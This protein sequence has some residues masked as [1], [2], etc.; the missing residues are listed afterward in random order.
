MTPFPPIATLR[1]WR[2]T[3]ATKLAMGAALALAA[4]VAIVGPARLIAQ[5]EGERGIIPMARSTDIEVS[6]VEVNVSGKTGQEAREN[7]WREAY[8]KAWAVL[9]GPNMPDAAIAA[10]VSAVVIENEQIGPHRYIAKLTV[11]FDRSK[12]G[13]YVGGGESGEAVAHSA[14][15]LL[16]PLLYSG[17]VGQV[18]E[19]RGPWQRAWAEFRAGTSP[20]DYVRPV[21][22]GGDSLLLTA[23]QV[24]RRSRTWWR[25]VLDEFGASDV[26]VPVAR[27]E[28]QWPGGPVRG[29][30]TARYGP[31]NTFLES[32]AMT[33]NDESG[34]PAM[35]AKAVQRF[36]SIY[37]QALAQGLLQPDPTLNAQA[38]TISPALAALIAESQRAEQSDAAPRPSASPGAPSPTPSATATSAP[39]ASFTIQ[40]PTPDARAVDTA[41]AVVRSAPGVQGASTSSIAIGGTSVVRASFA[42]DAAALASALRGRGW[43]VSVSGN[44]LTVHR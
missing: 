22:G 20:I 42:G 14:P 3:L 41:L 4:A 24:E 5:I 8:K 25:G 12:A 2:P 39:A 27:L 32:F 43:Q 26:I 17:G 18:Y 30:F 7:G 11:S 36:D 33:A 1:S 44:V 9:K 35:L 15:M 21:G 38:P 40:I 6:G 29:F 31:D 19:V 10:M 23:G 13:Q 28:R 34:V 16:I 37:T